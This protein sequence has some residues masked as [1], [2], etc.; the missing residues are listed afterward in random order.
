PLSSHVPVETSGLEAEVT[1]TYTLER[2]ETR[3]R[4]LGR[5]KR[6]KKNKDE[7]VSSTLQSEEDEDEILLESYQKAVENLLKIDMEKVLSN[8]LKG[9]GDVDDLIP[10]KDVLLLENKL[11][12]T[13]ASKKEISEKEINLLTAYV[14]SKTK[15]LVKKCD[16]AKE[17]CMEIV[18]CYTLGGGK[19]AEKLLMKMLK[20]KGTEKSARIKMISIVST[21]I[22][23][24][25][26]LVKF[27]KKLYESEKKDGDIKS[28]FLLCLAALGGNDSVG[29]SQKSGLVELLI[30]ILKL[31]IEYLESLKETDDD[32]PAYL[33]DA[34]D[35]L[36][37]IG[38]MG[39]ERLV[40]KVI[41][42]AEKFP[43][44]PSIQTAAIHALRAQF[45]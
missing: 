38:N 21:M 16:F 35:T 25:D 44:N 10:I 22:N 28:A 11:G 30:K 29:A 14:I 3:K 15:K 1:A 17:E 36:E 32:F 12:Y 13:R 8:Y 37:A 23:P 39:D 19:V 2:L 7:F 6:G 33:Q 20:N 5:E 9:K 24:S 18:Q 45:G 26:A 41:E 27:V 40:D 31:I 34:L 42:V 43:D 4:S